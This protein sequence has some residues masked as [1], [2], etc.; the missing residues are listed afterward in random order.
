MRVKE[1]ADQLRVSPSTVRKYCREGLIHH[2]L[3]PAG[4]RVFTQADIDDFLGENK[5]TQQVFYVRS[6]SGNKSL[7][8]SQIE[9]LTQEYGEPLR[10]YKDNGSGLNENRKGLTS[11]LDNASHQEFNRVCVTYG[12]RLSRFGLTYLKRLLSKDGV[13]LVIL[14][15]TVKYSLEDELLNDFMSL[16]ASFSGKF[17]RLRSKKAQKSLL[18]KAEQELDH[19]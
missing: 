18:S 2:D 4:Q 7:M 15:D 19:E 1:V 8:E 5:T 16:L 12:D 13:E 10:I 9:E 14:N 11:L 6:S 17:Y 3:N